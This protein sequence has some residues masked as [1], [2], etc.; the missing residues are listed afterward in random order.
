[1]GR[2][3]QLLAGPGYVLPGEVRSVIIKAD[4][5]WTIS[6]ATVDYADV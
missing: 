5:T 4:T 6:T 2:I 3:Q 1:M